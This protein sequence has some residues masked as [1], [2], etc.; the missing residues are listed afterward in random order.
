MTVPKPVTLYY[1]VE[2]IRYA[3][4]NNEEDATAFENEKE[5]HAF[6]LDMLCRFGGRVW[7]NNQEFTRGELK[8]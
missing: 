1:T 7:I 4:G 5:A 6:A 2:H 3:S 8:I